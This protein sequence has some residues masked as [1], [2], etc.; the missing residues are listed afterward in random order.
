MK[1]VQQVVTTG[2]VLM[3]DPPTVDVSLAPSLLSGVEH[4]EEGDFAVFYRREYAAV[5]ALSYALTG[6]GGV[7]ED[8]AQEAFLITHQRWLKVSG[9]E[10]PGAFVRRVAANLAVSQRRRFAA[11]ARAKA[12]L[13]IPGWSG[14]D[15]IDVPDPG[16]WR[17]V[18]AL[19]PRQAQVLALHY[20]EDR[21]A[22]E[23]AMILGCSA[24]T[25]RVHLHRG[26]LALEQLLHEPRLTEGSH[27]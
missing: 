26:R 24:S 15:D 14:Q 7:A 5:V 22:E 13:A 1:A 2:V 19:P 27:S 10:K 17:A 4:G 23:I 21:P 11:E 18:R 25:V 8:V 3:T 20:L 9:Y 6:R 12:R 16:F